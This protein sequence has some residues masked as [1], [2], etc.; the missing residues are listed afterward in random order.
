MTKTSAEI[1]KELEQANTRARTLRNQLKRA[2]ADELLS[3]KQALGEAVAT[4]VF[5]ETTEAIQALVQ[6]LNDPVIAEEVRHVFGVNSTKNSTPEEPESDPPWGS[7]NGD[8][9]DG[10]S[11]PPAQW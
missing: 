6:T 5:A 9:Q 2:R 8:D 3:A 1:E 10:T 4:L 7:D 11:V